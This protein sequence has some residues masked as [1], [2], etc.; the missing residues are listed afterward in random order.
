[1]G[2]PGPL[3]TQG[4]RRL[5]SHLAKESFGGDNASPSLSDAAAA[6]AFPSE[7]SFRAVSW[8]IAEILRD[9]ARLNYG[10]RFAG[11]VGVER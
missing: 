11:R 10:G 4:R 3:R 2:L 1:M 6:W 9:C 7:G 8:T 5:P